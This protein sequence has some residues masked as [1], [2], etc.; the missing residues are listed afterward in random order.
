MKIISA[1]VG[2]FL[3]TVILSFSTPEDWVLLENSNFRILFPQKPQD[4]TQTV[5]TALGKL[6]METYIYEVPDSQ[7]DDNLIYML[8]QTTYPDTA[9]NSD[10]T[11]LI[12]KFFRG[13]IDGA[14]K[15]VHGKLRSETIIQLNGYP[16]R[17]VRI[18]FNEGLAVIN[19]R[20]YL[21]KNI[22]YASETIT[23]SKN[24][25]NKS[26]DKFFGSFSLK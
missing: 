15:S 23:E 8:A 9:I 4:Q 12:D 7:K 3:L 10:K 5:N 18:D 17:K 19:M 6:N 14:V 20:F 25:S 21:V 24:D 16:G 11:G 1:F 22:L 2:T 26:I 13:S